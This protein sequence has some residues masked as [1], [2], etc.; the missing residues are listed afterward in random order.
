[1]NPSRSILTHVARTLEAP[2]PADAGGA[3]P[4]GPTPDAGAD[5]DDPEGDTEGGD[6]TL[7][8]EKVLAKLKK[9]NSENRALRE[10]TKAAE[11]AAEGSTEKDQKIADLESATLRL[12]VALKHGLNEDL[13]DR[14]RGTTEEELLED[15]EKILTL[16][17]GRRPPS[18]QPDEK[19]PKILGLPA[20]TSE[21][22][23]DKLGAS[24]FGD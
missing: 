9:L 18:Q 1:M 6:E 11:K 24:M 21:E 13:A 8:T 7:D 19:R 22:D 23:L 12:R 14:L 10:R 17:G 2:D 15:A 3:P 5:P 4:E 20:D 16:L